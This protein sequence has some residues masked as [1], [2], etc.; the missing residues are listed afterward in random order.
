MAR[1]LHCLS[2]TPG[3]VTPPAW[4]GPPYTIP[5]AAHQHC[6]HTRWILSC[7]AGGRRAARG[8][9]KE[10]GRIE[11]RRD[12]WSKGREGG[13]KRWCE[14]GKGRGRIEVGGT[15]G[16]R[17][18]WE[19]GRKMWDSEGAGVEVGREGWW[20]VNNSLLHSVR[21]LHRYHAGT[22]RARKGRNEAWTER[23]KE[24]RD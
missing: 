10:R 7:T 19:G 8:Q 23:G 1:P 6:I 2:A 20:R 16:A 15:E 11:F 17:G 3:C 4:L 18:G 9:G 22:E 13:R 12:G 21:T 24:R 14:T 5:S